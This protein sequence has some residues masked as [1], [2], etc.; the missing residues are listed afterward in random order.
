MKLESD[1][2]KHNQPIP[3]RCA[4]GIPHAT[5]HLTL[6][7]NR[8]PQL[9]WSDIPDKSES[10]VLICTDIDVPSSMD[11]FNKEGKTIDFLLT[12]RR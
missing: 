7:E 5:E 4:F 10:L 1:S 11:N 3:Q 9:S 8:N 12:Y 6:G 2:F